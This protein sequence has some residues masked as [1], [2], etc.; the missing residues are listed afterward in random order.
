MI[1]LYTCTIFLQLVN[2]DVLSVPV[3]FESIAKGLKSKNQKSGK[4]IQ[5]GREI[6]FSSKLCK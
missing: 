4:F 6:A 5:Q 2:K 3:F 1:R